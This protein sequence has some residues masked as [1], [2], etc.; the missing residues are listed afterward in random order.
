MK[1][2]PVSRLALSLSATLLLLASQSPLRAQ[3]P[4]AEAAAAQEREERYQKL[5]AS[6]DDLQT[7]QATLQKRIAELSDEIQSLRRETEKSADKNAGK[8]VARDELRAITDAVREIDRKREEDK[9][10]ILEEIRKLANTPVTLPEAPP[11]R[12]AKPDPAADAATDAPPVPRNGYTYVVKAGD[13]LEAIVKAYGQN[14]V[15]VTVDQVLK[16]NP[17]LKPK[18]MSVNQKILIPDPAVP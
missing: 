3:N 14:G 10:L 7:T 11:K 18:S 8:F 1:R 9:K 17:K 5:R 15:K 4:A 2:F 13:T 16:A 6:V 12:A